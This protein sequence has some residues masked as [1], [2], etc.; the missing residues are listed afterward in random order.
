M[1]IGKPVRST[2]PCF[3]A[4]FRLLQRGK[5]LVPY[6]LD[7]GHYLIAMD[8]SQYF[9]SE[10]IHCLSCLTT[11]STKS[12]LRYSHQI[13]QA[14]ML[15]PDMR[16]VIPLAPEPIIKADGNQNCRSKFSFRK[17]YWNNLRGAIRL[18]LFRDFEHLLRNMADPPEIRA[19]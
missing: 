12:N 6:Q 5:Q 19:P 1:T 7:S 13:L 10:T 16:Q 14:V 18:M 15:H 2:L 9:C 4:L 11:K 3:S 8:G 17:E